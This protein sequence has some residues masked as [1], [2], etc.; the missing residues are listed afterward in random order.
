MTFGTI[1]AEL[2]TSLG[3][4]EKALAKNQYLHGDR[5]TSLDKEYY[6]KIMPHMLKLSPLTHPYTFGWYG[7][8]TKFTDQARASWPKVDGAVAPAAGGKKDKKGKKEDDVDM[9]DLF[10]DDGDDGEAAKKAAEAAKQG[11]KK[12]KKEVIAMSL[13]MLEV[14]PCDD[15]VN[16][17]DLA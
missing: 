3:F 8:V 16:L 15:Q 5:L 10:G 4:C 6:D 2:S 9:D 7:F 11:A 12:K 1:P 13:V 14:K 17:D